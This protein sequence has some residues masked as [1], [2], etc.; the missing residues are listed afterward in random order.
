VQAVRQ[1]GKEISQG[2][3]AFAGGIDS[4]AVSKIESFSE[5]K[6]PQTK[7]QTG[8]SACLGGRY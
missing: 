1:A 2:S 3:I 5:G 6:L 4:M 8:C 7:T